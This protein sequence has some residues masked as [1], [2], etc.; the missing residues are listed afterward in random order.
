VARI[1]AVGLGPAGEDHLS[2]YARR[3]LD[4]ASTARL[5][6]RR[7]PAADAFPRIESFDALYDEASDFDA[8]YARIADELVELAERDVS[9]TAV[10]AVPGSPMVAER[11]IALLC[12]RDDVDVEIVPAVSFVD[13]ACAVLGIDPV[14]VGLRLGD[15]LSMPERLRG[16]GPLLLAQTHSPSVLADVALRV[17][18]ELADGE[19]RAIVLHHLGLPDECIVSIPLEELGGFAVADHLTSV[20]LPE[21]RTAGDAV[22]DL[23]DLMAYL[24]VKCPWD[25]VHT[26][27]SLSRYLLE[28]TYE[29]I[30]AIESLSAVLDSEANDGTSDEVGAQVTHAR[31]EL[32]DLLVQVVFHAQLG[33]EEGLF[34]VRSIADAVST[35]LV[36]RHPH[37]FGDAIAD[38]PDAVASRWE[39]LKRDE[40]G[41]HSV[42]DGIPEALPALSLMAKVRRKALAIGVAPPEHDALV[43]AV[44]D[45]IGALPEH[46]TL[47]DDASIADDPVA[48]EAIGRALES[49]CDLARLS[50]V[51]PEQALRQR[52]R[53]LSDEVRAHES[54]RFR[55]QHGAPDSVDA[56]NARRSEKEQS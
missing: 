48:T 38:T 53:R 25:T 49:I 47:V 55:V 51:D 33:Y 19:V 46:A 44:A 3:L 40:K 26:H 43:A 15:A 21:L 45:A 18:T 13:L 4:S 11:T 20:F 39:D 28:E 29:A 50:G 6:T 5:R 37:V 36:S 17:D 42:M 7:H 34:D 27:S 23:I 1:V 56:T 9:D 10:Y 41:R 8:L 12:M 52:A 32:G 30:D 54:G 16:P 35:K 2:A 22:G 24:R 31:E 14:D